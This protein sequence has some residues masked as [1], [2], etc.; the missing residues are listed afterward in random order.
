MPVFFNVT[1]HLWIAYLFFANGLLINWVLRKRSNNYAELTKC[2]EA[3]VVAGFLISILMNGFL[4]FLLDVFNIDFAKAIHMITA[5]SAIFIAYIAFCFR[6]AQFFSVEY[7]LYRI[8]LYI[9]VFIVLFYNGGLIEHVTDSWWHMSYANKIAHHN[10]LLLEVGHLDGVNKRDYPILWHANLALL[11]ALSDI[12][13]PVIWNSF[14]AWGGVLKVMSYYLFA[15]ALTGDR[16][17]GLL[18]AILFIL[19][20][21]LHNSYLRLSSWPSHIAYMQLFAALYVIFRLI[22]SIPNEASNLGTR[23]WSLV[24][25]QTAYLLVLFSLFSLIFFTHLVEL[26]WLF[27]MLF[28]YSIAL[29]S[30][31]IWRELSPQVNERDL[32]SMNLFGWV[33]ALI[34]VLSSAK[35]FFHEM[36]FQKTN[37]DLLISYGFPLL[38][39]IVLLILAYFV[40]RQKRLTILKPLVLTMLAGL[41]LTVDFTQLVSLVYPIFDTRL[42][43]PNE[44]AFMTNGWFNSSLMLP[45]WNF[46]LRFGL[47]YSAVLSIPLSIYLAFRYTSR[48]TIFI[49]ASSSIAFFFCVSPYFYHW[50]SYLLNYH[51]VWRVTIMIFHPLVFAITVNLLFGKSLW[52]RAA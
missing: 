45:S 13:L 31:R 6:G 37:I 3:Q 34:L 29:W 8:G 28:A 14:T 24:K 10:T 46:Q 33:A 41:I 23:L 43:L 25:N 40:T 48:S 52:K 30:G 20:P 11:N 12:H 5:I 27:I 26:V 9:F 7:S 2:F 35:M 47:L 36:I 19:L 1:S 17:V 32:W 22:D 51:S 21:G 38:L 44:Q 16:K 15:Y 39:G 50:L 4:L 18:S 42:Q 49:A